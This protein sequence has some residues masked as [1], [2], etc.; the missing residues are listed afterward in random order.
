LPSSTPTVPRRSRPNW[1]ERRDVKSPPTTVDKL[2]TMTSVDPS[3]FSIAPSPQDLLEESVLGGQT[4]ANGVLGDVGSAAAPQESAQEHADD[5][6]VEFTRAAQNWFNQ[7]RSA[8]VPEDDLNVQEMM[9]TLVGSMTANATEAA[10]SA[11]QISQ[12]A[13]VSLIQP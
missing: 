2:T 12:Q 4:L 13:V 9:S 6:L 7:E 3:L 1:P 8:G 10:A 11:A 5:T